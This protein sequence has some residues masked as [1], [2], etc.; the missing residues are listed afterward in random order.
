MSNH[1]HAAE[2]GSHGSPLRYTLVWIA[3]LIGTFLTFTVATLPRG[4]WTLPIALIIAT[5]KGTLVAMFFMHL[6]GDKGLPKM[7]LLTAVTLFVLLI[8]LLMTDLHFRFPLVTPRGV[9]VPIPQR[10]LPPPFGPGTPEK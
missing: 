5:T 3:L 7:V 1:D 8:S 4:A 6:W 9:E 10:V 2:H